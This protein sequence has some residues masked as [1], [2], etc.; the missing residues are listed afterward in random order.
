ML[1]RLLYT[2]KAKP[3]ACPSEQSGYIA[4]IVSAAERANGSV[5]LTGALL[6]HEGQFVQVLEGP[7][8]EV[9]QTF[10]R[11]CR[12]FRHETVR[13]LDLQRV[14]ARVFS[15]WGMAS[16]ADHEDI[17][18]PMRAKIG[19]IPYLAGLNAG[20]AIRELRAVLDEAQPDP[21]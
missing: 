20:E 15:E 5:G 19:E 1:Q 8:E 17:A 18:D 12:D 11:I 3:P 21:R 9:E 4:G 14:S 7:G 6:Y 10:E 16:V 13:L 2:S